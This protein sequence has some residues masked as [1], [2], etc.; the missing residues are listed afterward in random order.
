MF[1]CVCVF[2]GVVAGLIT[3]GMCRYMRTDQGKEREKERAR[4]RERAIER[5]RER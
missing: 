5:E 2:E 1:V 3:T 4:A